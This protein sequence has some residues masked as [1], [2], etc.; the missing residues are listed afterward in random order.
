ME[1]Q[2]AMRTLSLMSAL[3]GAALLVPVGALA[4]TA[5]ED[6][7]AEAPA[8]ELLSA[9]DLQTM[10]GPVALYP[11]TV[12]IQILVAA[13]YPLDIMKAD[14]LLKDNAET[15]ADALKAKVEA[16][17]WDESVEVLA[18]AF[19]DV[20][21]EMAIHIDWTEAM[22]TAMLAQSDDVMDAVQVMRETASETGALASGEE[23]TVEVT[24]DASGDQTI[25][26]QPT[27]PEVVYVPQYDPEVVYVDSGSSLST[28]DVVGTALLT[29]G[30]VAL[31]DNIFDDDDPWNDYWGCRNCGGW[32]GGPIIH[33]PDIDIDIDGDVNIGD[34]NPGWK[35]E[36]KR[37]DDAR[38]KIARKKG[39]DGATTLPVKRPDRGDEMRQSLSKKTGAADISRDKGARDAAVKARPEVNRPAKAPGGGHKAAVD[40][41]AAPKAKAK[42]K[43]HKPSAAKKPA[44]KAAAKKPSGGA[45]HKRASA[46]KAKAGGSR[47]RAAAGGHKRR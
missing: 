28:G 14:R 43:A 16:E 5:S 9:E 33:N 8:D 24:Q 29:F 20:V 26:I 35:P 25:I 17:G 31:I 44:H 6:P 42:A 27:D 12:L 37:R 15:D 3:L 2:N 36:D 39:P 22:G 1:R 34:R 45:M 23:Q 41:T 40:R 4:Q 7:A 10:V 32:G 11:D 18:T 46:P 21:S 13:T 38:D 19:P 47:G 30:T